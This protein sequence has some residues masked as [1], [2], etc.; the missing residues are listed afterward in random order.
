MLAACARVNALP[1]KMAALVRLVTYF[2]GATPCT[3]TL[4]V[5]R[6]AE[7]Q[8]AATLFASAA[9]V[10]APA[11]AAS[12]VFVRDAELLL[13]R[14]SCASRRRMRRRASSLAAGATCA[15]ASL[16]SWMMGV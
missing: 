14:C 13:T 7:G 12:G 15:R 3:V 2:A 8:L 4:A 9:G 5:T 1:P 6:N 16:K 10:F 11:A